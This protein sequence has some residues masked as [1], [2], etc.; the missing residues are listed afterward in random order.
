MNRPA[1]RVAAVVVNFNTRDHLVECVRSLRK[2]GVEEI[3]VVDNDSHDGS[4]EALA[5]ADREARFLPTG[6]N[7]GFGRAANRGAEV[8]QADYI[9]V[10]NPDLTVDPDAVD[11]LAEVLDRRP[12]TAVV[13]PR[14][15]DPDGTTYPSPRVFPG[16]LDA[17]G[18]AFLGYVAPRN[19][20]TRRY[21]ML[22][23]DRD[24]PAVDVDWVS[25]S[26][27]LARRSAWDALGGFDEGYF[28]YAED[29]DLCWRAHRAGWQVAFEPAARVT[30]VQGVSTARRPYRMIAEHHR[31]LLRFSAR[32]TEGPRRLLLPVVAFGLAVRAVVAWAHRLLSGVRT[33]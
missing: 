7:L 20:F 30:H 14:I 1:A 25:G 3:V 24:V 27:F 21:R 26:C 12:G 8:A 29:V 10:C 6:A 23:V 16:L 9:L 32:T 17:V 11:I 28:M 5:A 18:H 33:G 2:A 22:D 31:S 13:G 15:V 4:G 19:R